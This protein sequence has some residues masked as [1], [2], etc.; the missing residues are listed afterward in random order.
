MTHRRFAAAP[1]SMIRLTERF[2]TSTLVTRTT[3]KDRSFRTAFV[4]TASRTSA[5]AAGFEPVTVRMFPSPPPGPG[6]TNCPSCSGTPSYTYPRATV[7]VTAYDASCTT[8]YTVLRLMPAVT[9][10]TESATTS[11]CTFDAIVV[12]SLVR[13]PALCATFR[14]NGFNSGTF[15]ERYR[16]WMRTCDVTLAVTVTVNA[17]AAWTGTEAGNIPASVHP[18]DVRAHSRVRCRDGSDPH[19]VRRDRRDRAGHLREPPRILRAPER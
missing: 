17:A 9:A 2:A 8:T 3:L 13:S 15:V 12:V 7:N 18:R 19:D 6:S 1:S 14:L 16:P 11:P 5:P 10:S 4:G